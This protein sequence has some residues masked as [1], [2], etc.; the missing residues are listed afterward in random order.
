MRK[1]KLLTVMLIGFSVAP[2]FA[3]AKSSQGGVA[4]AVEKADRERTQ[5]VVKADVATIDKMTGDTYVFTDATGRV[6][7]KKDLLDAFKNGSIKIEKQ[8]L[9]DLQVHSYGNTVVETGKLTSQGTRQGQD[10]SG[11]FRF[12][13][14]W[15]NRNGAWQTVAFQETKAQ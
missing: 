12:T 2:C 5:A 9:S 10:V 15:V 6:T 8:E 11:T 7:T 1:L 13:R 4:A 14:V 3:Q